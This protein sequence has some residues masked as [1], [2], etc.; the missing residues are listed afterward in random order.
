M[1]V[2]KLN[3]NAS[4][5]M[6]NEETPMTQPL[7]MNE[8]WEETERLRTKVE[9][10]QT[11]LQLQQDS[12]ASGGADVWNVWPYSWAVSGWQAA[13]IFCCECFHSFHGN[14]SAW[15]LERRNRRAVACLSARPEA[16]KL[17]LV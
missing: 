2:V 7:T 12:I 16:V 11:R 10:L 9:Q 14:L 1:F 4:K 5:R 8:L 13:Q 17:E 15:R 6:F 3:R